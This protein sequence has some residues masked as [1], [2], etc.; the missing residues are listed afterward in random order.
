MKIFDG[1]FA[2]FVSCIVNM[3]SFVLGKSFVLKIRFFFNLSKISKAQ[4][5]A[6]IQLSE[7][8]KDQ[9]SFLKARQVNC[10]TVEHLYS[11]TV[12]LIT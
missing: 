4:Q 11:L 12:E 10:P 5:K 7:M 2:L 9:T 6:K 8:F 1:N 3:L